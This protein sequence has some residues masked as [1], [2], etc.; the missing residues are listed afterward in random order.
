MHPLAYNHLKKILE[1]KN[2][3]GPDETCDYYPCH[4]A[5]QDCTWCF[6]PFYPCEDE[7]TGGEWVKT[8]EGGR[9]W[10]CSDCFWMHKSEV[11]KALM[12]EFKRHEIDSVDDIEKRKNDMNKIFAILK[13]EYPPNK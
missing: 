10:S 4:F 1:A 12:E 3:V 13:D 11:A 6:C 5:G 9:I 2:I 7:Q 8:K